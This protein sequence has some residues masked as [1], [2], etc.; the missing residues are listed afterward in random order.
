MDVHIEPGKYVLAVSGGVDS[1]A[2]LHYLHQQKS[3]ELVVAHYDHGI[4]A[5]SHKDR[6]LVAEYAKSYNLLFVSEAGELGSSASEATARAARYKFLKKVAKKVDAKAIITAHHQDDMLETAIINI[7]RGTG[8][9]GLTSLA[10][11]D[12]IVRPLLDTTKPEIIEYAEKHSLRWREDSTNQDER[13]LR[14]YIR[15]NITTKLSGDRNQDLTAIIKNLKH[16]NAEIDASLAEDLQNNIQNSEVGRQWFIGLPHDVAREVIITW[17]RQNKILDFDKKTIE[18]LVVGAKIGRVGAIFDI[19][20][21]A[22]LKV[23]KHHL[24]LILNER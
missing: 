10:S 2:L 13:Y 11:S 7:M 15:H 9:R 4:R 22:K 19:A 18:R 23:G 17:L 3:I 20:S 24:A 1:I 8:R 5:D 6:E 21:G 16:L 12:D 14:N